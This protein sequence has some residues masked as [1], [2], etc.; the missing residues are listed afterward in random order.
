[1][2]EDNWEPTAED[3]EWTKDHY[4]KMQVGDTWG[5]ADAVLMKDEDGFRITKAT[6]SSILPLERIGKVCAE[7]GITLNA[8]GVEVVEDPMQAAQ[9]T[10]KEWIH[11]ES[12]VPLV[13]FDLENAEWRETDNAEWRVLVKHE[14]S[15]QELAP[16]DFHLIAGDELF[17]SWDG[18]SV[19]ERGEIIE[20]ADSGTLMKELEEASVVIMPSEWNGQPVPPHL[21]GLIFNAKGDE[22]E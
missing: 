21:R 4:E 10:A 22:E 17:F 16:M 11:E 20:I 19:L 14:D 3:I 1:M 7:I 8:D 18:M 2:I 5:I 6:P 15:E 13:N 9:D 12:G